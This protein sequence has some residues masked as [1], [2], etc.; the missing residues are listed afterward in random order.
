MGSVPRSLYE[1]FEL[2]Q[3]GVEGRPSILHFDLNRK[4]KKCSG[5]FLGVISLGFSLRGGG[6]DHSPKIVFPAP[7]SFIVKENSIGPA[8]LKLQTNRHPVT[9]I[10]RVIFSPNFIKMGVGFLSNDLINQIVYNQD[11]LIYTLRTL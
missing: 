2:Q 6:E 7:T 4:G 1:G 3:Q 8:D 5:Y 9:F 10:K 11:H